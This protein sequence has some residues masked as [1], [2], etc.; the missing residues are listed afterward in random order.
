[1]VLG[2]GYP[3]QVVVHLNPPESAWQGQIEVEAVFPQVGDVR[4]CV[5]VCVSSLLLLL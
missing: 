1:M 5:C 2:L 3:L 4:V